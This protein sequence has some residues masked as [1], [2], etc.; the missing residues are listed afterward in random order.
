MKLQVD[1]QGHAPAS[2]NL[3]HHLQKKKNVIKLLT[4]QS[5]FK[6][7]LQ[8]WIEMGGKYVKIMSCLQRVCVCNSEV[9]K[10]LAC[11]L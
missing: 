3:F 1:E 4:M 2:H 8:I 5:T 11:V 9:Q 6:S 10:T 7:S